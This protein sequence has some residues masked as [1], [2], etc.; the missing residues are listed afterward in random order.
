LHTLQKPRHNTNET[1]VSKIK[2]KSYSEVLTTDDKIVIPCNTIPK[3]KNNAMP[4]KALHTQFVLA[5]THSL[6]C[7][8][9]LREISAFTIPIKPIPILF[10]FKKTC[11]NKIA[12]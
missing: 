12:I 5:S 2:P 10:L 4:E 6:T 9:S 11:A 7:A 3:A 1:N 8:I